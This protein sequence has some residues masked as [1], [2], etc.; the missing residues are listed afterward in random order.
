M[1]DLDGLGGRR[2]EARVLE[3][4]LEL[5]QE[6]VRPWVRSEEREAALPGN[7]RRS[8]GVGDDLLEDVLRQDGRARAA[9]GLR[10]AFAEQMTQ[11]RRRRRAA[12]EAE[13]AE[14]EEVHDGFAA[15]ALE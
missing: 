14:A 2:R 12:R 8:E 5:V 1:R 13:V 6:H 4:L 9:R 3:G 7:R 10:R 11:F 15:E